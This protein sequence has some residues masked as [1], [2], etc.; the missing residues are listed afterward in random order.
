MPRP[1]RID[2]WRHLHTTLPEDVAGRVELHL[3][4]PAEQ[5]IPKGAWQAFILERIFEF[6]EWKT[7]DLAPYIPDLPPEG[8]FVRGPRAVV[9]MLKEKLEEK[10]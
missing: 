9:D 2:R 6:F 4:S 1:R 8:G 7:L 3:Y 5:R 10:R